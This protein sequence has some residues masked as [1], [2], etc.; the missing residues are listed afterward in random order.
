MS[1]PYRKKRGGREYGSWHVFTGGKIVNLK[2]LSLD[3]AKARAQK[4]GAAVAGA[5]SG[6]PAGGGGNETPRATAGPGLRERRRRPSY[7]RSWAGAD[8]PAPPPPAQAPPPPPP[9]V[10]PA[11]Q[12][13]AEGLA[14]SLAQLNCVVAGI[15]VRLFAGVKAPNPTDRELRELEKTYAT[16]LKEMMLIHGIQWWHILLVQNGGLVARFVQDGQK[17]RSAALQPV[18]PGPDATP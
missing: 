5:V 11:M 4:L 2:T 9:A 17:V 1:E 18:A 7:L 10:S 12:G 13:L 16:G 14:G 15:T 8:T 3:E 6:D